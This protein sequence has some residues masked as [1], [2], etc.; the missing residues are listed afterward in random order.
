LKIYVDA[1][2]CPKAAKEI[3]FRA[4]IRTSVPL[5]QVANRAIFL[6][7]SPLFERVV[8]GA[9]LDVADRWIEENAKAGDLVVTADIPLAAKVVDKNAL[10]LSPHGEIF[11]RETVGERLSV[12]N[13]MQELRS[14]G[15]STGGPAPFSPADRE[16]FANALNRLLDRATRSR[17]GE[18]KARVHPPPS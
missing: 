12:R 14:G 9:G 16:R 17:P 3:L 13:F 8:V 6:P 15:V 18:S 5:V 11:D 1:D 7:D 10:A 4:A 2:G